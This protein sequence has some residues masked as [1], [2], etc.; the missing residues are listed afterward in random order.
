MPVKPL[1]KEE[2]ED[3]MAELHYKKYHL[4]SAE[5]RVSPSGGASSR[6][7]KLADFCSRGAVTDVCKTERLSKT[8]PLG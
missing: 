2:E 1:L 6:E 7:G 3:E 4:P 8:R 5:G